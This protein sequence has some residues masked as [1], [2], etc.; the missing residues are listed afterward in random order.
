MIPLKVLLL[1]F[2]GVVRHFDADALVAIESAHGLPSGTL[3]AAL[4][5]AGGIDLITGRITH[6]EF[7]RRLG[8]YVG[9]PAAGHAWAY[10]M[11]FH[12]DAEVLGLADRTRAAGVQVAVL[13]NG[14]DTFA[15]DVE[16][17][18][19]ADRFDHYFNTHTIGW[20]KPSLEVYVHVLRALDVPAPGTLFVDDADRN[21]LAATALGIDAVHFTGVEDLRRAL[22]RRGIAL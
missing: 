1:D 9:V 22:R 13:T 7:A 8:E 5:P 20:A 11:P 15:A 6:A 2:D 14:S 18:G 4:W 17:L 16:T 10:E 21:V 12:A 3:T 19:I